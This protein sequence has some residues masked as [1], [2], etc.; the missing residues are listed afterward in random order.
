MA[1]ASFLRYNHSC[2]QRLGA[3]K[4]FTALLDSQR[5]S[6]ATEVLDRKIR[7]LLVGPPGLRGKVLIGSRERDF[8]NNRGEELLM[9]VNAPS[10]LFTVTEKMLSRV[11]E[12]AR[13]VGLVGNGNQITERG[14]LL[15]RIMGN[16]QI[17]AV[18]RGNLADRNPFHLTIGERIYFLY[19]L[20]EHDAVWPFLLSRI[21][22]EGGEAV[23]TGAHA[24]KLTTLSLIDLMDKPTASLSG[25]ELLTRREMREL[26]GHMAASLGLTD[27]R[28]PSR[29]SSPRGPRKVASRKRIET[30][31]PQRNTADDQAIPRFENLVDLGLLVKS[32]PSGAEGNDGLAQRLEW[33]YIVNAAIGRWMESVGD[34]TPYDSGFLWGRFA[35]CAAE[36]FD[37]KGRELKSGTDA[38]RILDLIES[39]YERVH[40]P[41]GHTPLESVC[42]A[43]MIKGLE[44]GSICE[45]A[46]IHE[47]FLALK[48]EGNFA[49]HLKFASGN[50]LDRMFIDIRPGFFEK[51]RQQHAR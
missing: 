21:S 20:L 45:M 38:P 6:L 13:L 1:H 32:A 44:Q 15:Q 3:L 24:C 9:Q 39:E 16:E 50:E 40:R 7:S 41:L 29:G 8:P 2:Q 19:L 35:H 12:W 22:K 25:A 23:I 4:V 37:L 26:V 17:D 48:A 18:R 34:A 33:R 42:L 36:A 49:E 14:L 46:T 10:L 51:V 47:L 43:A 31:V 28:L 27:A 11:R 5:R 30:S